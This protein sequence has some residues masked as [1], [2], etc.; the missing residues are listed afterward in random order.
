MSETPVQQTNLAAITCDPR[1]QLPD[2]FRRN[3]T[4]VGAMLGAARTGLSVYELPPGQAVS[5]YHYEDPDEE[6]LLVVSG[7]PTLRHPGGEEQLEPWD[8]VFF[9]SGPAGAHLV[10]NNSESTARVAMFSSKSSPVGAVVYPDTDM[11]WMW[12]DD[13]AVDIVVERS[14]AVDDAAPWTTGTIEAES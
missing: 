7:M 3:S 12:T 9:P 4:R 10:R 5:P 13:G 2:G 1:P 11:V 8:L 6:W 14:S